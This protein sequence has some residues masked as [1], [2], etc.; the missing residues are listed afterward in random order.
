MANTNISA[1]FTSPAH[2]RGRITNARTAAVYEFVINPNEVSEHKG[3][4]IE[5]DPIPGFSDPKLGWAGG[6]TAIVKLHVDLDAEMTHRLRGAA[7]F[8]RV[9]ASYDSEEFTVR[10]EIAFF[11]HF[12]YPSRGD[13]AYG[14][15]ADI[16]LLTFGSRYQGDSFY[17]DD[18]EIKI[19][20]WSPDGEPTRAS[21]DLTLKKV[22]D[23]SI[24]SEDIFEP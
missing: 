9:D 20:E 2:F 12:Q 10:N 15:G 6:K 5:E 4:Y 17:V 3:A 24:F 21:V 14:N 22:V 23:T 18:I 8:N 1:S 16:A 11:E 13:R 7:F 19:T